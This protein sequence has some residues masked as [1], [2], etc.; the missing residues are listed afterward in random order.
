ME[1]GRRA[2]VQPLQRVQQALR[3]SL[4]FTR[5]MSAKSCTSTR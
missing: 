3:I 5:L 1:V 4:N 2:V